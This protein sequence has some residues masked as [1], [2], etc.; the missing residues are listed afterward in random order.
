[1]GVRILQHLLSFT[2]APDNALQLLQG[3][4]EDSFTFL[5][6]QAPRILA[7]VIVA[8]V[9][10]RL[11]KVAARHLSQLSHKQGLPS[12]V[13]AQ[14]LRT[15]SSIIYSV[16]VFIIWF[17]A[18]MQILTQLSIKV[19]P[20]LASAGIAG[21]A[22]GFGS[23]ALVKDYINGFLVLVENQYDI[24]DTIKVAG[25]QGVVEAITLRRTI[26]RD[27]DGTLHTVPSSQITIVSNM[28][29]DWT[30]LPMKVSVSYK[31]DSDRVIQVLKEVALEVAHDPKFA[32]KIVAEPEVPGIDRVNGEEVEYLLLVKT[33]PGA[34]FEVS[35]ELRR[36]IKA[37]FEKNGIAPGN[38]NRVYMVSDAGKA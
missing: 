26:L 14:Q 22:V 19:E 17:L 31:A 38:P 37:C 3:W 11:L 1:M 13:R 7:I 32:A 5:R 34:Q 4:R 9:L 24:G 30:Q 21:L 28:T 20:L 10:M 27:A 15:L 35:R 25:V 18:T 8:F 6:N 23:Q 2:P 16:G 36:R 29:R 33:R 12:A